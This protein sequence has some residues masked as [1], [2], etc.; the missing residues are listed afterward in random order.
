MKKLIHRSTQVL[1]ILAFV[2][3]ADCPRLSADDPE[4]PPMDPALKVTGDGMFCASPWQSEPAPNAASEEAVRFDVSLIPASRSTRPAKAVIHMD[5]PSLRQF[6]GGPLTV[7]GEPL[8]WWGDADPQYWGSIPAQICIFAVDL[9]G[10]PALA[11]F[12]FQDV[13]TPGFNRASMAADVV[14]VT[15]FIP[16]VDE[17]GK[18][19]PPTVLFDQLGAVRRGNVVVHEK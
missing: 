17:Y 7:R 9:G 3:G 4:L 6:L 14:G 18:E 19:L 10:S 11:A 15:F 8:A 5:S 1:A 16:N 2:S 13:T 12:V